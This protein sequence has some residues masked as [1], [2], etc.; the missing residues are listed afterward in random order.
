MLFEIEL[1]IVNTR[2][3]N[4][5][6][7]ALE[8]AFKLLYIDEHGIVEGFLCTSIGRDQLSDPT[9]FKTYKGVTVLHFVIH[10]VALLN[11]NNNRLFVCQDENEN[12]P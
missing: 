9:F 1:F 7:L 3:S 4:L 10:S 5:F 12:E 8:A 2:G 6:C 11:S